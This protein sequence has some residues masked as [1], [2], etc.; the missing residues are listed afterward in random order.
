MEEKLVTIVVLPYSKAQMLK[1]LLEQEDI[2][3]ILEDI[4]LI[5]EGTESVKVKILDKNIKNAVPVLE[6]FLG[7]KHEILKTT[8]KENDHL[9]V[10]VDFSVGSL[11]TCKLAFN[12]AAHLKVKLVFM[13]CYINPVVHSVPY[14]DVYV[15]DSSLLA[16]MDDAEKTANENFAKFITRLVHEIGQSKWE[17]VETDFIIKSGYPDEDILAYAEKN[18]SRLI[19]MGTGGKAGIVLGSVTADIVYNSTAPVLVIPEKSPEKEVYEFKKV[20]YATNFDEKDFSVMDK[21]TELMKP[22]DIKVYCVHVGKKESS[23]WDKA[24]LKGMKDIFNSK[25][26]DKY[27]ECRLVVGDDI[28]ETLEKFIVDEEIDILSL[29]THKRNMISRLFNPSIARKMVFH[30]NTPLLVFHA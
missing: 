21:L 14:A 5:E 30:S 9:L 11:K 6:N 18:N 12:I 7:K 4:N 22:F 8:D 13:H 27:F 28:L 19:V 23:D 2:E 25:Y 3:C 29:T 24:K 17:E 10:P 1:S 20:L 15:Y 26:G 16:R